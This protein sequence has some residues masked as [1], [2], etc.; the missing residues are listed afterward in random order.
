LATDLRTHAEAAKEYGELKK[1]LA[2]QFPQ[3]TDGY[4]DGK[5][6][7]LLEMLRASGFPSQQ[8]WEIERANR[9]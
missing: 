7:L 2:E 3:D 1:R 4:V 8:L 6:T 5:T 9:R